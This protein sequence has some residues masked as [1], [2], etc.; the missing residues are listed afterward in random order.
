[1]H[2]AAEPRVGRYAIGLGER[3]GRVARL[4]ARQ[5][6]A[7]DVGVGPR[8]RQLGDLER[9]LDAVVAHGDA[10]DPRLDAE[11]AAR[12]VDAGRD[13][14]P[15]LGIAQPRDPRVVDRGGEL[16]VDRAV[17]RARGEVLVG[18]VAVVLARADDAADE[19]VGVEEVEEVAPGEAIG[20]GEDALRDLEP[21]ALGDPPYEVRRRGAFEVNVELGLGDHG[22]AG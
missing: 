4:V 15:V 17:A 11:V 5:R 7:D 9:A 13:A 6:E 3:F 14:L 1:V 10:E 2:G 12:V 16:D 22:G 8:G 20:R 19:V 21:V 18:D